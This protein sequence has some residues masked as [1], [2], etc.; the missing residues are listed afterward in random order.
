MH[1][2]LKFNW[3]YMLPWLLFTVGGCRLNLT[4]NHIKWDIIMYRTTSFKAAFKA[5]EVHVW[6]VNFSISTPLPFA[7]QPKFSPLRSSPGHWNTSHV[8]LPSFCTMEI[9]LLF[10][11]ASPISIMH[12][13]EEKNKTEN[14]LNILLKKWFFE[15]M[16]NDP[17]EL[18]SEG[19]VKGL[20][21]R[22]AFGL[23]RCMCNIH[24]HK[25]KLPKCIYSR[26][27]A[28][29]NISLFTLFYYLISLISVTEVIT[30]TL[31]HTIT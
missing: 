7:P 22:S 1:K 30:S 18:S 25:E 9:R 21:K 13:V 14:H 26:T 3:I 29:G 19:T 11:P 4:L 28:K 6:M 5:A 8:R 2:S 24:M 23:C 10:V 20:N 17:V 31:G 15:R 16:E 27:R 12:F